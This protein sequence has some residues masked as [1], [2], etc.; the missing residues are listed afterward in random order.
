L[1]LEFF[2]KRLDPK[3]KILVAWCPAPA[4]LGEN[5]CRDKAMDVKMNTLVARMGCE[6]VAIMPNSA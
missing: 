6:T 2:G 1:I 3:Q 5:P 4:I